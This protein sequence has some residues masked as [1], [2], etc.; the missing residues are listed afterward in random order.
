MSTELAGGTPGTAMA[1]STD[2]PVVVA[3]NVSKAFVL[4]GQ[5]GVRLEVLS[6]VNLDVMPRESVAL[7]G[8]S[9]VGKSTLL[10]C[11]F[12]N[13]QPSSGQICVWHQG[14]E[15]DVT[16]ASPFEIV[17]IR[18]RTIG[19][20]SQFLRVIPRVP[21]LDVVAEPAVVQGLSASDARD[22]AAHLLRRLNI[23]ERL[24]S[25]APAT[26]SGGEQQRVNVARGLV[27]K[28]PVL[29]VDEPTAS[30]DPA[31]R[32]VVVELINEARSAG[33]AVIG[34]FHDDEVRSL[35]AT[36][37]FTIEP[38]PVPQHAAGQCG[39]VNALQTT[40]FLVGDRYS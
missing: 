16:A 19:W 7:A 32:C 17:D 34:I 20:V 12:G 5:G 35:I 13:Y 9:G 38:S 11:L 33:A 1:V 26:F 2:P 40:E 36:R 10:R 29:L 4:H 25:L 18:R 31:N 37:T 30:L 3:R 23:P 14:T 6:G 24:W 28:H 22:A 8:P 15:V 39:E 21:T 27:A